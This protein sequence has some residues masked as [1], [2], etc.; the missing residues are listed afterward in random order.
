M[1][2]VFAEKSNKEEIKVT[3]YIKGMFIANTVGRK[4]H[5]MK[6]HSNSVKSFLVH[7]NNFSLNVKAGNGS[8]IV[9][10][11]VNIPNETIQ[12]CTRTFLPTLYLDQAFARL[13]E[14]LFSNH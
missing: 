7:L 13:A 6:L 11:N 12:H 14:S 1:I 8:A 3:L 9:F 5:T 10:H 4:T 2:V